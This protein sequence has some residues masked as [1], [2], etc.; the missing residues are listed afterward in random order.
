MTAIN[1]LCR[2]FRPLGKV[3]VVDKSPNRERELMVT[4]MPT[5]RDMKNFKKAKAMLEK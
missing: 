4:L 5:E 1:E 3:V 2:E